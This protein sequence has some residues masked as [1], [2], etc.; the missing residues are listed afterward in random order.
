MNSA[1]AA[2]DPATDQIIALVVED[3]RPAREM[4]TTYLQQSGFHVLTA[5]DGEEAREK[6]SQ[7]KPNIII[8]DVVLP[9]QSGF[10]LCREL[11]AATETMNIPVILCSKKKTTIDRFWGLRQG[12]DAYLFK[13]I[14]REELIFTVKS[15][16]K[17]KSIS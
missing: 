6:I 17:V 3:S 9:G 16:L 14:E 10:E 1:L 11:K 5:I 2:K 7:Y 8:L 12:A 13:P 15:C 4:L